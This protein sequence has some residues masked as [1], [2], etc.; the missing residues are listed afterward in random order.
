VSV[1]ESAATFRALPA[2]ELAVLPGT[3]HPIE[4]LAPARLAALL[5]DFFGPEQG[6]GTSGRSGP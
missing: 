1:E 3:A 6:A 2:G 5:H 4:Q